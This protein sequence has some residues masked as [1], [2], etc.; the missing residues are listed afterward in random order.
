MKHTFWIILLLL[1][2]SCTGED[3]PPEGVVSQEKMVSFLKEAYLAETKVKNLHL[4]RDSSAL[5]F[6]HYE[7][8]LYEKYG[9]SE[10]EFTLSYNYYL[11][12]PTQLEDINGAILD[13]LG[14]MESLLE[15]EGRDRPGEGNEEE[16]ET[17][18]GKQK[19]LPL[20][21]EEMEQDPEGA[22]PDPEEGEQPAAEEDPE[23]A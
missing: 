8:A 21:P 11:Q 23:G 16:E 14:V 7:L 20:D 10:E 3:R 2:I 15:K 5:L 17:D 18:T 22:M 12:N 4:S 9:I 13:S 1:A 19:R 6:R